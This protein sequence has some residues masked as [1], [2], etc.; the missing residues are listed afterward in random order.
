M[1]GNATHLVGGAFT[2]RH[3]GGTSYEIVLRVIRDCENGSPGAY[4]D[5]PL[6][7]GL[8]EK[9]SNIRKQVINLDFIDDDTLSFTGFNCPNIVTGCTHIGTYRKVVNLPDLNYGSSGGYYLSWERCCRNG[10][11][12]N[13]QRPGDAAMALYAEIPPPRFVKN[14]TPY[15]TNNPR[16]LMCVNNLFKYNMDFVDD[17]NDNLKYTLITPVN[18]N[19]DRQTVDNKG[20]P[21]S[22]P[23]SSVN[24]GPGYSSS[25]A[26]NGQ[27][28]LKIDPN[29]GEIT[30][31]P[32]SPGIYVACILVEEFRFGIKIGEVRLE[33]QFTV[34]ICPNNPP[35]SSVIQINNIPLLT[36]TIEI[37]VGNPTC[38]TISSV[39]PEKDSIY[40]RISSPIMDSNFTELPTFDTL[41]KGIG[42]VSTPFCLK[43]SCEHLRLQRPFPVTI[44]ATDNACPINQQSQKIFWVRVIESGVPVL[45][46]FDDNN[47]LVN[48]DTLKTEV[49]KQ[50]CV[51]IRAV[52]V[53]DPVYLKVRSSVDGLNFTRLPSFDTLSLGQKQAETR[54][55]LTPGCDYQKLDKP[56][57]VWAETGDQLCPDSKVVS[58]SFWLRITPRPLVPSTDLLCMTLAN[59]QETYIYWGDSSQRND[60]NFLYYVLFR[61]ING[62]APQA[63]DTIRSKNQRYFHDKNTPD[64]A[65][66]NYRYF[67]V[68]YNQ[69]GIPGASSDSLGTFEQLKYIPD[70]QLLNT[71]SVENKKSIRINWEPSK[72]NDFAKYYLYKSKKGGSFDLIKT[73]EEQLDNTWLD[74]DV[75]V[76]RFSYCYHLVMQD[77]CDNL[78][79]MGRISCTVLLN[80]EAKLFRNDLAWSDYVGWTEG[81]E[82]YEILRED[83]ATSQTAIGSNAGNQYIDDKLNLEEGLFHYTIRA[84]EKTDA[85]SPFWSFSNTISLI[86]EP[87]LFVPNAFTANGDALNDNFAWVPVF[88]KDFHIEIYSRWGELLFETDDKRSHWDGK[89]H[90]TPAA[91]DIYFYKVRFTG[92]NGYSESRHGNFTLLR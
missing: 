47:N 90:G 67:M 79:P 2:V 76:N 62:M 19:L 41:T 18:G 35:V 57:L 89:I 43:P 10:I 26:I 75:E 65:N 39:D 13:I 9:G 80:G 45:T 15:Y 88:I 34:T 78:G 3:L 81:V 46:L 72:E 20:N 86:Q 21:S 17:D 69:C 23:Y 74:E 40:L 63:I 33:L 59:N 68:G 48:G 11:I 14:S 58:D 16:T 82:R 92:Y 6:S 30:C 25:N 27:L 54:F 28:P 64:Y 87:G 4:F 8:F 44:I 5:I 70:L 52:D 22:G 31:I 29:T 84:L 50:L 56:F 49:D 91:T 32:S 1:L 53:R 7:V 77:T 12:N 66:I 71:V 83:P 55:C 73:F 37:E 38:L 42:L 60:P 36:D 85:N 24:W 61:S 51:N